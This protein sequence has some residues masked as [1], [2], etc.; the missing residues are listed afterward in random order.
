MSKYD[1]WPKFEFQ[2][3]RPQ[4][5]FQ[6]R[7]L[8]VQILYSASVGMSKYDTWLD[9][10]CQKKKKNKKRKTSNQK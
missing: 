7:I 2:D 6:N 10:K 1:I 5:E 9:F 4:L 8:N 3:S